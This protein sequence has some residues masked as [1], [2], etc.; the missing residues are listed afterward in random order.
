M[1][2]LSIAHSILD[3][4]REAVPTSRDLARLRV[5]KVRVG[6]LSGVLADSLEFCFTALVGD[7]PLS[8]ARLAI[9]EVPA[10]IDCGGCGGEFQID[11][12][13]FACPACGSTDVRLITGHELAV[14]ELELDEAEGVP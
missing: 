9:E 14:A 13:I 6:R 1:H 8:E 5:V 4:V 12:P 3:I 2:E 7:T 10:R 11:D